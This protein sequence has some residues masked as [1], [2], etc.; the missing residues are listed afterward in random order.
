MSRT[1]EVTECWWGVVDA[2]MTTKRRVG[3]ECTK[4]LRP[5]DGGRRGRRVGS[6]EVAVDDA[7]SDPSMSCMETS[8]S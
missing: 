5:S 8:C 2:V 3:E 1:K 7:M 4:C 6:C